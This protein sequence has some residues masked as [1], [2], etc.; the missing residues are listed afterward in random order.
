MEKEQILAMFSDDVKEEIKDKEL[1]SSLLMYQGKILHI[2]YIA[3]NKEIKEFYDK[4]F[5][6]SPS[7]M[8]YPN[9]PN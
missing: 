2:I 8:K 7:Y 5:T 4:E 1:T 6:K 3:D 9:E